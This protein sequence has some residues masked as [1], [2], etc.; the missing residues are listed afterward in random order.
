MRKQLT[1]KHIIFLTAVFLAIGV[2]FSMKNRGDGEAPRQA[3]SKERVIRQA[4][5][6]APSQGDVGTLYRAIAAADTEAVAGLLARG[7]ALRLAEGTRVRM[8]G[9]MSGEA[10]VRILSG[11]QAGETCWIPEGLL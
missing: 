4:C 8:A 6:C 2:F 11:Y 3:E 9:V 7:K 10:Y 1:I 5:F